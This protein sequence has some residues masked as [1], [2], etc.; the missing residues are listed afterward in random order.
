MLPEVM[1]PLLNARSAG[2]LLVYFDT[3]DSVGHFIELWDNNEVYLDLFKLVE[4]AAKG[5]DG[6]DP[7]A[8]LTALMSISP[9]FPIIPA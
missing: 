3:V 9:G 8:T 2:P 7:G 5:W 4:D 6:S 1:R